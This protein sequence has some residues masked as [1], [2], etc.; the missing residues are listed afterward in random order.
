MGLG[1]GRKEGEQMSLGNFHLSI[2]IYFSLSH[3]SILPFSSNKI[4]I[5]TDIRMLE[6]LH[7]HPRNRDPHPRH[8]S[9]QN[10]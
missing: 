7:P 10:Q 1:T 5:T 6:I 4:L 9:R 2:S 3:G 8:H